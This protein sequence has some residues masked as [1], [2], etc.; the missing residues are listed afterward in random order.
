MPSAR[1]PAKGITTTISHAP[2]RPLAAT[3]VTSVPDGFAFERA[4]LE[5]CPE[6][7]PGA[8]DPHDVERAL[9]G[10]GVIAIELRTE[11]SADRLRV[12]LP[13]HAQLTTFLRALDGFLLRQEWLAS[14]LGAMLLD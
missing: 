5:T 10:A 4:L 14:P 3:D 9:R 2:T 1:A 12:V 8:A 11:S 7:F 13:T 6:A